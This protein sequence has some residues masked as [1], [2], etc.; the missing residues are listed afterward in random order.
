MK[1]LNQLAAILLAVNLS[2]F[3]VQG[4]ANSRAAEP[5]PSPPEL[6]LRKRLDAAVP[7]L[8]VSQKVPSVSIAYVRDE[9]IDFVA[10]YGD[11]APGVPAT[12]DT[13]YN[14]ASLTKPLAAEVY[15]RFATHAGLSIDAPMSEAWVD[16][17]LA[18]DARALLLTPRLALSHRTGF[19]NWR[20]QTGGVLSFEADPGERFGYSGEGFEYLRT[21]LEKVSGKR[22]DVLAASFIFE[23]LGMRDTFFGW[24]E[25]ER[26]RVAT[27]SAEGEWLEVDSNTEVLAADN[28]HTTARDY[29]RFV[30]SVI[31]GAGVSPEL[32]EEQ[33][34]VQTDRKAD[35]CSRIETQYCPLQLGF[36]LGWETYVFSNTTMLMHTGNDLGESAVAI[37]DL[38]RR[39]AF[40]MLTNSK[41]GISVAAGLLDHLDLE[42]GLVEYLK[43]I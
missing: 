29:A 4:C 17:D 30:I 11:Q 32:R 38:E 26:D 14:V 18:G 37:V 24:P 34:R 5:A 7:A 15:L 2:V 13:L 43:R 36:G 27:P 25:A 1:A 41:N 31:D 8:L 10:A 33:F 23:P 22:L 40:V 20:S 42:P 3:G 39:D 21:Y 16:P 12:E 35:L 19:A 9:K 28:V 6:S